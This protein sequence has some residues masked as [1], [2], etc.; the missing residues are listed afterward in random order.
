MKLANDGTGPDLSHNLGRG[1]PVART[2]G[3]SAME[4][5]LDFER[6][7]QGAVLLLH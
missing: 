6:L 1:Q 5:L 4:L 2:G 7:G 3:V